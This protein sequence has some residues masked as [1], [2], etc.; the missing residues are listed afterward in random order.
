MAFPESGRCHHPASVLRCKLG[1][2][3]QMPQVTLTFL[4]LRSLVANPESS[5]WPVPPTRTHR[6]PG[7]A[8]PGGGRRLKKISIATSGDGTKAAFRQPR[9]H[10][11]SASLCRA[12]CSAAG[13]SG[14]A[15]RAPCRFPGSHGSP[16]GALRARGTRPSACGDPA[17]CLARTRGDVHSLLTPSGRPGGKLVPSACWCRAAVTRVPSLTPH[18]RSHWLR[19]RAE[20]TSALTCHLLPGEWA[21]APSSLSLIDFA[22]GFYTLIKGAI[23]INIHQT[24]GKSLRAAGH[25]Q[26]SR[27]AVLLPPGSLAST[28]LYWKDWPG[29]RG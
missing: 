3:V 1:R 18:L 24:Q 26:D 2:E 16:G 29:P 21:V 25:V 17:A 6:P 10:R 9:V 8:D 22:G 14:G 4:E 28:C 27:G 13:G 19:L 5:T 20:V 12:G 23:F 7:L 15:P 11:F